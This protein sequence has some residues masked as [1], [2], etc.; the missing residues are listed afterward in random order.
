MRI[1][2]R[3]GNEAI[4]VV[5]LAEFSTGK[6]VELV[7]SVQPPIPRSE[8]WVL[9]VSTL[10]GCP[11]G[12]SICD[13]GGWYEGRLSREEILSQ[14]D[15]L[16]G[17]YYPD[18]KV[19]MN[20]FKIQFAR[21]G[22][23][24]LNPA[25]LDVL[26]ELPQIYEA[27]G[28]MPSVSTIAPSGTDEFFKQLL[29][30]KNE[31]YAAG[32]FQLQFSIHS[33]D[34]LVR[35][36]LIPIKKWDFDRI[37]AYGE[38]FVSAGDRKIALNFAL[39]TGSVVSAEVC[40]AYFDPEV[41]LIKI[42]P[43]NP[44]MRAVQNRIANAVQDEAGARTLPLVRSLRRAGFEVIISIGEWEENKIGSNCGQ[45]IKKFLDTNLKIKDS[46]QYPILPH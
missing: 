34:P 3:A 1:V 28:L 27:P 13:A 37:A 18:R 41:F 22:E 2:G 19:P 5:Y 6:Y 15:Y 25:V 11:V 4:A 32:S 17:R 40:R 24:A 46:Y 29:S 23:P 42:T 45:F 35:D 16:V 44:T 33:T 21:M 14:I 39:S 20:K 26:R 30:I 9:I 12:C 36:R 38:T 31:H 43:V 10:F 7:E 8:K